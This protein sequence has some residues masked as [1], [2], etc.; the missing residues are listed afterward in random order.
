MDK[1]V[2]AGDDVSELWDMKRSIFPPYTSADTQQL[3]NFF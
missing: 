3:M 2:A 1:R